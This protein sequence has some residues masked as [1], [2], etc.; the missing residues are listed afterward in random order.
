MGVAGDA[1]RVSIWPHD[2]R[3]K[4]LLA[5]ETGVGR[6]SGKPFVQVLA[7]SRRYLRAI[8]QF[9]K[10]TDVF[11]ACAAKGRSRICRPS[12]KSDD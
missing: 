1:G 3:I 12:W 5:G 9:Q 6:S 8:P 7:G 4:K 11:V 10:R 2:C